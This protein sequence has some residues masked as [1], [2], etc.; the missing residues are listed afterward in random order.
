MVSFF[1]FIGVS[2]LPCCNFPYFYGFISTWRDYK[3]ATR[4]K[5]NARNIVIVPCNKISAI[6]YMSW[7]MFFVTAVDKFACCKKK[8][9]PYNVL[10]HSKTWKSQNFIVMSAEQ[11][12]KRIQS[13]KRFSIC[14]KYVDENSI[15]WDK[16]RQT[17]CSILLIQLQ[18]W[19]YVAVIISCRLEGVWVAWAV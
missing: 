6:R 1:A 14:K 9:L 10:T 19:L 7:D 16:D 13:S 5:T 8:D 18:I 12:T 11:E 2:D 17:V 3:I 4:H 15:T